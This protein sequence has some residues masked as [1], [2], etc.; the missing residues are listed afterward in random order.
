[1]AFQLRPVATHRSSMQADCVSARPSQH[2]DRNPRASPRRR[3]PGIGS[4]PAVVILRSAATG[5]PDAGALRR[6][7]KGKEKPLSRGER[8][9]G[10][11]V[12][13]RPCRTVTPHPFA[14]PIASLPEAQALSRRERGCP[15]LGFSVNP[16]HDGR[17]STGSD[18]SPPPLAWRSERQ[19]TGGRSQHQK[20]HGSCSWCLWR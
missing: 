12:R 8:G 5:G 15:S 3:G 2:C 19:W 14:L 18:L 7:M 16:L 6:K 20:H 1:M 4:S 17:R 10:E 11:G 9:W 13:C